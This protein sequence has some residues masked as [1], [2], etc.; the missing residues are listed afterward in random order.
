MHCT[1]IVTISYRRRKSCVLLITMLITASIVRSRNVVKLI[2]TG[3]MFSII[4]LV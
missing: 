2:G 1:N 3:A 4:I